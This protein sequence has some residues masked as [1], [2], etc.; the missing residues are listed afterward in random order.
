MFMSDRDVDARLREQ[1]PRLYRFARWLTRDASRADDLVQA[2][3]EKALSRW[4]GLRDD[5]ALRAWLFTIAYRQF[6]DDRRRARRHAAMLAL[7]SGS[8]EAEQ[9]SAEREVIGQSVIEALQHLPDAQRHLL[10]WVSV[11]GLSYREIAEL[12]D[13]PIGTV[14]SRLS[15]ARAELRRLSDGEDSRHPTLKLLKPTP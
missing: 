9:P 7:V 5:N 14:M 4:D 10:L 15:R 11:E 13:V 6:L 8:V 2:T 3:L 12:L 1:L